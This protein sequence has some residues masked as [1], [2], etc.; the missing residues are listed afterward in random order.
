MKIDFHCHTTA[1]DGALSPEQ[2]VQRAG[3]RGIELLS[4]TDHD[5]VNAYQQLSTLPK[6]LRLIPGIELSCQWQKRGIHIV[7]L[8]IDPDSDAMAEATSTQAKARALRAEIIAE[9]LAKYGVE[10]PLEGALA[11]SDGGAIGRPHFARHMVNTGFVSN[12]SEAFK[13]FLGSGKTCDIKV[14]WPNP[15]QAINW[16]VNAGGVAVLAHPGKYNMTRSKLVSFLEDFTRWGGAAMEVVSGRQIPSQTTEFSKLCRQFSLMAS[17]GSDFHSPAQTWLDLGSYSTPPD[18][19]T[20]VWN[21]W[22]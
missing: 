19:V 22:Q 6:G 13:K 14:C 4:I 21:H 15:E 5:S 18:D 3:D 7:G 20:P 2:L 12:E 1:S 8:N 16:I 17:W 11:H 10:N 9:K